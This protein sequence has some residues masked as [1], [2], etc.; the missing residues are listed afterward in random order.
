MSVVIVS[1]KGWIVIPAELREKYRWKTGDRVKVVD[2]GGLVSLVPV[3]RHPE[4][5]GF[6]ALKVPGRSLIRGL[7]RVRRDERQRARRQK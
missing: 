4:D 1:Q 6:G 3:L 7:R 2:Y 5:E